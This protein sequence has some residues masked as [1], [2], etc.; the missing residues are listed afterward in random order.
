MKLFIVYGSPIFYL[1]FFLCK[2]CFGST[3]SVP[4]KHIIT[5]HHLRNLL[6]FIEIFNYI[7]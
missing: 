5:V 4:V 7:M 1:Y 6:I 2:I 3:R